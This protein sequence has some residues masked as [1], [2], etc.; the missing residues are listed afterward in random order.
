VGF[1]SFKRG[2]LVLIV[3]KTSYPNLGLVAKG[4]DTYPGNYDFHKP[5][6]V[7][8]GTIGILLEGKEE[9]WHVLVDGRAVWV[10]FY[11]LKRA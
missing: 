7:G 6:W 9:F 11:S 4:W 10:S 1:R 2:D 5:V 3:A 8:D